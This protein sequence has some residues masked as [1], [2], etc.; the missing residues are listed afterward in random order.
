MN[1]SFETRLERAG[2]SVHRDAA[3]GESLT[4][5]VEASLP[6]RAAQRSR[7]VS[8]L[9]IGGLLLALGA[10]AAV[11][12]TVW[13][14]WSIVTEPEL[15]VERSWTDVE[16]TPL[17]TCASHFATEGLPADALETGLAY[18]ESLDVDALTADPERV[19]AGLNSAGRL[20]EIGRLAADAQPGDFDVRHEGALILESDARILQDAMMR[21][22]SQDLAQ[23]IFAEH[24]AL[25]DAG[26]AMALETQCV[27]AP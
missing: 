23:V 12:A 10:P 16:G 27:E 6:Q 8:G 5:M 9:G 2:G 21:S 7:W 17:G 11:A 13:G 22:V 1:E 20:D 25:G 24:A 3:V 26:I 15:V 14:P 19:A 4:R 18:L